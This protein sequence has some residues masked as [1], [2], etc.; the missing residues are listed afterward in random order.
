MP[1]LLRPLKE[2]NV[3]TYEEKVALGFLDILA[4]EADADF[5]AIY[6]AW[7]GGAAPAGPAGGDL[8]GV[9]PNPTVVS[10]AGDFRVLGQSIAASGTGTMKGAVTTA[11]NGTTAL[12]AN[13]P[14]SPQAPAQSSWALSLDPELNQCVVVHRPPNAPGGSGTY[15]LAINGVTGRTAVVLENNTVSLDML[16]PNA[17]V[18]QGMTVQMPVNWSLAA[19]TWGSPASVG[20]TT[21][22][23]SVLIWVNPGLAAAVQSGNGGLTSAISYGNTGVGGGT[24]LTYITQATGPGALMSV[25]ATI[26][27]HMP[28][29]GWNTYYINYFHYNGALLGAGSP[30]H[31]SVVE[32]G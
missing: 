7:N 27:H 30:G 18:R 20:I 8:T 16:Q 24:Y 11:A 3:R 14:W 4:S 17:T 2:G 31:I 15:P 25:P 9:Y 32:F 21:R 26:A 12:M 22:G 28:P 6:E 29:A 13:H 1:N 19:N 23:G 5:A 10:S